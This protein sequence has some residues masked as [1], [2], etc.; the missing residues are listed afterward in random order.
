MILPARRIS[1]RASLNFVPTALFCC[2]RDDWNP[3]VV[4]L[5]SHSWTRCEEISDFIYTTVPLFCESKSLSA[6][7]PNANKETEHSVCKLQSSPIVHS[8]STKITTGLGAQN[9]FFSAPC[10]IITDT[11][12]PISLLQKLIDL[13]GSCSTSF[14]ELLR[15]RQW[16]ALSCRECRGLW[17]VSFHKLSRRSRKLTCFLGHAVPGRYCGGILVLWP[18]SLWLCP[19]A[20]WDPQCITH[21]QIAL[22]RLNHSLRTVSSTLISARLCASC[23]FW[24]WDHLVQ[25]VTL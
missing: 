4:H 16:R 6:R 1:P 24:L 9:R 2:S 12:F 25:F 11:S 8:A 17:N 18:S 20:C 3:T 14:P 23:E 13:V 5:K 15:L 19:T 22:P 10:M 21:P 7:K